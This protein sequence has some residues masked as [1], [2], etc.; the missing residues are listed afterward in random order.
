M[1]R[2]GKCYEVKVYIGA[3]KGALESKDAG[4]V[5]DSMSITVGGGKN[6]QHQ[7]RSA[8]GRLLYGHLVRRCPLVLRPIA[9]GPGNVTMT[10]TCLQFVKEY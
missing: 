7:G 10:V 4:S 2:F 1:H 5:I 6:D 3:L 9:S 8:A